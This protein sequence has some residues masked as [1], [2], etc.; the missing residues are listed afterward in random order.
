MAGASTGGADNKANVGKWAP[1]GDEDKPSAPNWDRYQNANDAAPGGGMRSFAGAAY[2]APIYDAP[3]SPRGTV[4]VNSLPRTRG[5]KAPPQRSES[6]GSARSGRSYGS[7]RTRETEPMSAMSYGSSSSLLHPD[8]QPVRIDAYGSDALQHG[9]VRRP[10]PLPRPPSTAS[11]VEGD[12]DEYTGYTG[13]EADGLIERGLY[14]EEFEREQVEAIRRRIYER[15]RIRASARTSATRSTLARLRP[16]TPSMAVTLDD[17]VDLVPPSVVSYFTVT[18]GTGATRTSYTSSS[19]TTELDMTDY[20]EVDD[21]SLVVGDNDDDDAS[22]V[23]RVRALQMTARILADSEPHPADFVDVDLAG[24]GTPIGVRSLDDTHILHHGHRAPVQELAVQGPSRPRSIETITSVTSLDMS[25]TA[26]SGPVATA[27]AGRPPPMALPAADTIAGGETVKRLIGQAAP[28]LESHYE[29]QRRRLEEVIREEQE[30][31]KAEKDDGVKVEGEKDDGEVQKEVTKEVEVAEKEMVEGKAVAAVH[32]VKAVEV[33]GKAVAAVHVKAV[34]VEAQVEQLDTQTEEM[35][36]VKKEVEE[37]AMADSTSDVEDVT[38]APADNEEAAAAAAAAVADI[39]AEVEQGESADEG[40]SASDDESDDDEPITDKADGD[41]LAG[42]HPSPDVAQDPAKLVADDAADASQLAPVETSADVPDPTVAETDGL[43]PTN[44]AGESAADPSA[45]P[46]KKRSSKSSKR[47]KRNE[48]AE[49]RSSPQT[50]D[51]PADSDAANPDPLA[52]VE[53]AADPTAA[54]AAAFLKKKRSSKSSKRTKR[55]RR[56]SSSERSALREQR[57][58]QIE[59]AENL[60][61]RERRWRIE[62]FLVESAGADGVQQ[63]DGPRKARSASDVTSEASSSARM[64]DMSGTSSVSSVVDSGRG[65]SGVWDD[66]D[67]SLNG[68]D[69]LMVAAEQQ[70]IIHAKDRRRM[71]LRVTEEPE[72]AAFGWPQDRYSTMTPTEYETVYDSDEG[73]GPVSVERF[74]R[75]VSVERYERVERVLVEPVPIGKRAAEARRPVGR[76][77]PPN[78]PGMRMLGVPASMEWRDGGRPSM[79][80]L[81]SGSR[82][83]TQARTSEA[84]TRN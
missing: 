29:M 37:I 46:K 10:T 43:T 20:E 21:R 74:E 30:R 34:E 24:D 69:Q 73:A 44:I 71:M 26:P 80:T 83:S 35:E 39:E 66:E 58:L 45:R 48:P 57:V 1:L 19:A 51:G 70:A 5:H 41:E 55:R 3:G 77:L 54:G 11:F 62:R 36:E 75:G 49:V 18:T 28:N 52:Q 59:T 38:M 2:G 33:E 84:M 9:G 31:L 61:R 7:T 64:S 8:A 16:M 63:V 27:V 79:D 50:V 25:S 12:E 6:N 60:E 53:A 40:F 42:A 76:L 47:T 23:E 82:W 14:S 22:E 68:I 32:V 56:V 67:V 4:T 65:S 13:S 78:G 15:S 72:P 17:E 81:D